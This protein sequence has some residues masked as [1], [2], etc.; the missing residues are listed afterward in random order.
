MVEV[1]CI[2]LSN[3]N[4]LFVKERT[5]PSIIENSKSH[6]IEIIVVDNSPTQDFDIAFS[7]L[8]M[9]DKHNIKVIHSDPWHIPK[10]Y[11]KGVSEAKG[12]YIA[13]FHDDC[14]LFEDDKWIDKL[15]N[16]LNDTIWLV[17]PEEH[18]NPYGPGVIKEVP[19]MMEKKNFLQLGGY[20]ETYYV[21]WQAEQIQES[22]FYKDKRIKKVHIGYKHFDGMST[23]L[24][25]HDDD[26]IDALKRLFVVIKNKRT[27]MNLQYKFKFERGGVFAKVFNLTDEDTEK[28]WKWYYSKMPTTFEEMEGLRKALNE[29][30][31]IR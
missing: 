1:S 31:A 28:G 21:G 12:K 25:G 22:I 5:I 11:N 18:P 16:E 14:E 24:F 3:L 26:I 15:K 19:F 9:Y 20:D 13:L 10:A 23:I 4:D 8:T 27:F 17:G 29:F 6:N 7:S 2:I 30:N